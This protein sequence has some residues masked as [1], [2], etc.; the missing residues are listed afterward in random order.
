MNHLPRGG[1]A[2]S[3]TTAVR[4][5]NGSCRF[6]RFV[7]CPVALKLQEHLYPARKAGASLLQTAKR[8][9]VTSWREPAARIG[10]NENFE[11]VFKCGKCGEAYTSLREESRD[12]QP[13]SLCSDNRIP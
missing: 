13:L 7:A 12:D 11:P 3:I 2:H 9:F 1:K 5:D 8:K 10:N 6:V 4:D